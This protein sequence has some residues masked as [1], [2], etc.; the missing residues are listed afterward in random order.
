MAL[1]KTKLAVGFDGEIY[2]FRHGKV[3]DLALERRK[4]TADAMAAVTKYVLNGMP[5]GATIDYNIGE[6]RYS[7]TVKP[8]RKRR[9]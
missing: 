8:L 4:A 1:D 3:Q 6:S 2:L 5:K 9:K 7:M